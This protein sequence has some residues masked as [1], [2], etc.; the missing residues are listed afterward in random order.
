VWLHGIA[1]TAG[2]VSVPT[3]ADFANYVVAEIPAE[4]THVAVQL[5]LSG[6]KCNT[7]KKDEHD[8]RDRF[9]AVFYEWERGSYKPFTWSTLITALKSPVVGKIELAEKLQQKFC[10]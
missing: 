6:D 3:A 10:S 2:I 7:I 9:M 8:C 1:A 4:W 5:G